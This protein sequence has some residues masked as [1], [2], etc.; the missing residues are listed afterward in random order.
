MSNRKCAA[1]II[2]VMVL[3]P[4][5]GRAVAETMGIM[6]APFASYQWGGTVK[7]RDGEAKLNDAGAWGFTI[8][9]PVHHREAYLELS[10]SRQ[11][12]ELLVREYGTGE[13]LREAFDLSVEYFQ[14]GGLYMAPRGGARPFGTMTLGATRFAPQ[15]SIYS[16]EWLFSA[17]LGLGIFVPVNERIG[18]RTHARL[19]LPFQYSGGGL[20]CGRGGCSIGVSGG[21][22]ILQGDVAVCLVIR[23]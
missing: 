23:L 5:S 8:D 20:W 3:A 9:V 6:V 17:T 12:T 2:G 15:N 21:S 22:N 18:L 19:L 1:V 11:E 16:S 7:G 10:Y 4:M 14:I 13:P